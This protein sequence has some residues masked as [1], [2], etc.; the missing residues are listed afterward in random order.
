MRKIFFPLNTLEESMIRRTEAVLEAHGC[1]NP[2]NFL[3]SWCLFNARNQLMI[4]KLHVLTQ[5]CG[6]GVLICVGKLSFVW[7]AGFWMQYNKYCPIT[8]RATNKCVCGLLYSY[9]P[10]LQ[11]V[12]DCQETSV[13]S[14]CSRGNPDRLTLA[15]AVNTLMLRNRATSQPSTASEYL[16]IMT[17]RSVIFFNT[18]VQIGFHKWACEALLK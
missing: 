2:P 10:C 9:S 16:R 12:C 13:D 6:A 5:S 8:V 17:Y 1:N 11:E 18:V 14:K 3:M 15:A 4:P 7:I